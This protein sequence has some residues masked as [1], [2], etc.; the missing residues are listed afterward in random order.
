MSIIRDAACPVLDFSDVNTDGEYVLKFGELESSKFRIGDKVY[1]ELPDQ[2][3]TLRMVTTKP[4]CVGFGISRPEQV[5][6][7]GALADGV[8]VGSAIVSMIERGGKSPDL[9]ADVGAFIAELK[10]PL[11]TT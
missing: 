3:R 2:L 10:A 4:L 7:A 6:Q 8:V 1:A 5:V 11:R 9:V